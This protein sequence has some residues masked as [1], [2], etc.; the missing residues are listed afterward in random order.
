MATN[1]KAIQDQVI[2][3]SSTTSPLGLQV[4][5]LAI[6][7]GARVV[8]AAPT[9]E[10]LQRFSSGM[11]GRGMAVYVQADAT[12]EADVN[13]I[14]RTA[15]RTFGGF[16]TWINIAGAPLS[17]GSLEVSVAELKI[18]ADLSFWS[19]VLGSRTAAIHFLNAKQA[20]VIINVHN[21]FPDPATVNIPMY[22][23]S[24]QAVR[25]WTDGFRMELEKM[26]DQISVSL[27][28]P[29]RVGL[30]R[31]PAPNHD[32][33]PSDTAVARAILYCATHLKKEIYIGPESK[34][35]SLLH[36][37]GPMFT[38]M[39][40]PGAE[41]G[42]VTSPDAGATRPGHEYVR[43][44]DATYPPPSGFASKYP[45]ISTIVFAGI[46]AGLWMFTRKKKPS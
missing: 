24:R 22:F 32:K 20:G 46:G 38:R 10:L 34:L 41:P 35:A 31:S 17:G 3:V 13:R 27:I 18:L 12:N 7:I 40:E 29:G 5:N 37:F 11:N 33:H 43:R 23:A 15:T 36:E 28:Q 16:D 21:I 19:I 1:L 6:D 25:G 45:L 14:A 42:T 9:E 44:P 8:V 26:T 4:A 39:M 30:L 2:V